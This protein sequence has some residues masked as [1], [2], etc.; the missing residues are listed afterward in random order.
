[1]INWKGS[2]QPL[3]YGLEWYFDKPNSAREKINQ[4]QSKAG[5]K[6]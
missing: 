1:L 5:E 2:K 6:N 3:F 4:K